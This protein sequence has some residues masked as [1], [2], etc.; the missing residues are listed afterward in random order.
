[1][2]YAAIIGDKE[3]ETGLI[4]IRGRGRRDLGSRPLADIIQDLKREVDSR[5]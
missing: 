5:S 3:L 2:P 4:S 1:V